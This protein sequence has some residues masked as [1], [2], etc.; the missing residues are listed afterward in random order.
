MTIQ[1]ERPTAPDVT[2]QGHFPALTGLRA[3]ASIAVVGTHAAFW[4]GKYSTSTTGLFWARLDFGVALF[5]ALSGFLLFRPWIRSALHQS[6][7]PRVGRYAWNRALRILPAYWIAVVLA[8]LVLDS[9]TGAGA[10]GLTRHLTLTQIYGSDQL[11]A[12]L[13]QGW[14]LAVEAAFYLVLPLLGWFAVRVVCRNQWRP[15]RLLGFLAGL[16]LLNV[17]YLVGIH[18]A[19]GISL[20][21]TMWLP[22]HLS[23]FAGGMALAVVVTAAQEGRSWAR[24]TLGYAEVSPVAIW[25]LAIGFFILTCTPAAGQASLAPDT[26]GTAVTR[27]LLYACAAVFLMAPLVTQR[28]NLVQ[29]ALSRPTMQWLGLVSYELF[30]IHVMILE[31]AMYLLGYPI[32]NG[33]VVFAFALTLLLSLPA[34]WLLYRALDRPLRRL[35]R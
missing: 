13:T 31:F 20:S 22:A 9:P 29:K 26:A 1:A 21:S 5:F 25:V 15:E 4:T 32:F 28:T 11:H 3:V 17:G 24:R 16:G 27:N 12:G 19:E 8:F 2:M 10:E 6:S 7:V 33:S 35:H 34:A 30:L 18:H 23:W 14:S